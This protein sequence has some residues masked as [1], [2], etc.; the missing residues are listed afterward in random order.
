MTF[1]FMLYRR[2]NADRL[3]NNQKQIKKKR[4]DMP[5]SLLNFNLDQFDNLTYQFRL[6]TLTFNQ[7]QE[8]LILEMFKVRL[9]QAGLSWVRLGQARLSW[10][11]LGQAGLGW[12]KLGWAGLGMG[13]AV[14]SWVKLG[15]AGLGWVRLGQTGLGWVRLGQA[16]L[17]WVGLGQA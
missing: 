14:L 8:T 1:V 9:G 5:T 12:V 3:S 2:E 7:P 4:S 11:R 16:G 10:V 6:L 13:Q 15:Q 17:I